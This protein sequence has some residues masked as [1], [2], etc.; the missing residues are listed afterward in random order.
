MFVLFLY[1]LI[2]MIYVCN[3]FCRHSF[4]DNTII[5]PLYYH[6]ITIRNGIFMVFIWY[7]NGIYMVFT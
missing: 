5:I 6:Y 7:F 1:S 4:D 3:F 2:G